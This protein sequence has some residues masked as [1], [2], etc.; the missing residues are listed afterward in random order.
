[1]GQKRPVQAFLLVT[2]ETL[3]ER[4][5]VTLSAK[6]ELAL[7]ALD[8]DSKVKAVDMVSGIEEL[9]RRLEVL[10]GTKPE[11]P[12]D[13]SQ[14]LETER[15]AEQLA[16]KERMANAGGQLIGAAFAFMGEMIS[17]KE[18]APQD[19][20]MQEMLKQRL[21]ECLEKDEKGQLKMTIKLPDEAFLDNMAK[22]LAQ[23]L[24][25]SLRQ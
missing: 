7:A 6:H 15:E 4:L 5:L 10:L 3:E 16:R 14:K 9:K 12:L 17:H 20:Q 19:I 1:M 11:A 13:E 18:A 23:I 24:G 8:P 25:S 21:S 2:E 22:S